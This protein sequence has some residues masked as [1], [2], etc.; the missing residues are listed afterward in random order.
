MSEG[1]GLVAK[2]PV[3]VEDPFWNVLEKPGLRLA[4]L[5]GAW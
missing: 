4:L 1:L 5:V 2:A 3:P